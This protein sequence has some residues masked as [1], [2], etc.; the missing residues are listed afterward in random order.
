MALGSPGQEELTKSN[1]RASANAADKTCH[2]HGLDVW[3][4]RLRY[5][6]D[7]EKDSGGNVNPL[8]TPD[9]RHWREYERSSPES[10][11]EETV[12]RRRSSVQQ[13]PHG[14]RIRTH[15]MPANASSLEHPNSS[16]MTGTEIE[17]AETVMDTVLQKENPTMDSI[18]L[19]IG[20]QL[21]GLAGSSGPSQPT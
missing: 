11:R 3:S 18:H 19:R 14:A 21:R 17:Y 5:L 20:F 6:K 15:L 4:E 16:W 8:A 10:E 13:A 1:G 7:G 2:K 9:F 12:I